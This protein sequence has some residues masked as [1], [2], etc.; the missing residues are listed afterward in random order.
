ME[1]HVCVPWGMPSL[2]TYCRMTHEAGHDINTHGVCHGL[3][4]PTGCPMEYAHGGI[5]WGAL[6]TPWGIALSTLW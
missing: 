4:W 3:V 6:S 1:E 5:P 2:A